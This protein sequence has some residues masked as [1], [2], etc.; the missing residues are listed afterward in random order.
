[1]HC[2]KQALSCYKLSLNSSY[3]SETVW[4]ITQIFY[5]LSLWQHMVIDLCSNKLSSDETAVDINRFMHFKTA[6]GTQR[7]QGDR[8]KTGEV[9]ELRITG[10]E[11]KFRGTK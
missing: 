11:V 1:M 6:Y 2:K 3:K 8:N 7:Q 10:N 4:Q 5:Y 9:E